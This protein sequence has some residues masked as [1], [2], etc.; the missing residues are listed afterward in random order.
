MLTLQKVIDR[1]TETKWSKLYISVAVLQCI[2]IVVIQLII[3]SQNT[4]QAN[5]LPYTSTNSAMT[6]STDS[7]YIPEMAADRLGRIKWENIAFVGFQVWF[8][9]MAF[10]ATV[11]QNTAEILALSILNVICA[12]LGALEVVDGHKWLERL[13]T[14]HYS[15]EPLA[16][17]EKL[18]IALSVV[19][20][21]FACA[22]AYL[23]YEMSRQFGWNIYKKIGADI[24]VQRMYR[25]FQFF[26]LSLKIDIFTG[27]L[28]S[29]FYLIQFALKKGIMWESGIQLVVTIL[30]LPMLYFARTAGSTESTG[31][32]IAFITFQCIA[33]VHY[34]LILTQTFEPDNFWY[35]WIVLVFVSF[36]SDVIT[37]TLGIICMR[38]FGK[39]LKPF[40]Q[41]GSNKTKLQDLEMNDKAKD[42]QSWRIDDD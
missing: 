32:M 35:T 7:S 28:V 27:F 39:G 18:E 30:M 24:Q 10:D 40:V 3:C 21:A 2:F 15:T 41:R 34:V 37:I 26:V 6:F 13:K 4:L 20:M 22:L 23:S 9:G 42:R 29:I 17:A 38:N 16:L 8:V 12:I 1:V 33:I 31:R 5:M 11:Y 36:A 25:T 14:T 19:I